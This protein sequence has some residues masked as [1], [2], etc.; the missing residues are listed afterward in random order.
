MAS[1]IELYMVLRSEARKTGVS[2]SRYR[3]YTMG[4][5]IIRQK[6][7]VAKDPTYSY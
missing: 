4:L 7:G 6:Q 3:E 5:I 2:N 1:G